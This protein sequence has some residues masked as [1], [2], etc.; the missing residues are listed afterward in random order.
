MDTCTREPLRASG[1][2]DDRANEVSEDRQ[3]ACGL[4]WSVMSQYAVIWWWW[5]CVCFEQ[6]LQLLAHSAHAISGWP[7]VVRLVCQ[8]T[9]TRARSPVVHF[10]LLSSS[11]SVSRL[12]SCCSISSFLTCQPF[13]SLI[14]HC[15][16]SRLRV[17]VVFRCASFLRFLLGVSVH[18]FKF[19]VISAAS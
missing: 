10:S 1:L 3:S 15:R 14:C 9:S 17:S 11:S 16:M 13:P 2:Q 18:P 7:P 19:V 5:L 8:L 12:S 6:L 4:A